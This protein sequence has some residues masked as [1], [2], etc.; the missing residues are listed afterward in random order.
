MTQPTAA[1]QPLEFGPKSCTEGKKRYDKTFL[2]SLQFIPA[3]LKKPDGLPPIKDVVFDKPVATPPHPLSSHDSTQ[4]SGNQLTPGAAEGRQRPTEKATSQLSAEVQLNTVENAWKPSVRKPTWNQP[5]RETEESEAD[6]KVLL[7]QFRGILNKMMPEKLDRLMRQ[8]A[9]LKINTEEKLKGVVDLIFEKA[10]AEPAYSEQYAKMSRMLSGL[11]VRCQSKPGEFVNFRKLLLKESLREFQSDKMNKW[12]FEKKM[13]ALKDSQEDEKQRLAEELQ[14]AKDRARRRSLGH[15]VFMGELFKLKMI[16]G[17]IMHDYIMKLLKNHDEESLECLCKVFL[18]VGK[19]LDDKK[20]KS[21]IDQYCNQMKKIIKNRKTSFR[22]R[23]KL[24]DVLDLRQN[25][26]VPRKADQRLKTLEQNHAEPELQ[27]EVQQALEKVETNADAG[28]KVAED[29]TKRSVE[30]VLAAAGDPSSPDEGQNCVAGPLAAD[31]TPLSHDSPTCDVQE[32]LLGLAAGGLELNGCSS[33]P[34]FSLVPKPP[35]SSIPDPERLTNERQVTENG[36]SV[37]RAESE[38]PVCR[39]DSGHGEK[40]VTASPPAHVNPRLHLPEKVEATLEPALRNVLSAAELTE[41]LDAL[42]RDRADNQSISDWSEELQTSDVF[43]R[44]LTSCICKSAIVCDK[45]F[46]VNVLQIYHRAGL[47]QKYLPD[48]QKQ[49]QALYALQALMVQMDH[50][51]YLLRMFFVTLHDQDVISDEA[52][53]RWESCTDPEEQL[54][55]NEALKSVAGF[56]AGLREAKAETELES[57]DQSA[58]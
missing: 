4:C 52:F 50:P 34:G 57:L 21:R 15:T 7:K 31:V 13:E 18:T 17:H 49:L 40:L 28:S 38:E 58:S 41:Q 29:G 47:L 25:N 12:I 9:G 8:V 55:R 26:W 2:L 30:P 56:L 36:E 16:T 22:I 33:L 35:C 19:N 23:F 51:P 1:V 20:S 32:Q 43:L 6:A 37:Q 54:G 14:E 10:I 39:G 44:V 46:T 3:S 11:K 27:L 48:E 42:I 53:F 45:V 24:Q 5:T